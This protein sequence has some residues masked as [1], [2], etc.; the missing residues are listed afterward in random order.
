MVY[1]IKFNFLC[2][3]KHTVLSVVGNLN[4]ANVK[5]ELY[6]CFERKNSKSNLPD[7]NEITQGDWKA[8]GEIMPG[9]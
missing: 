5:A 8:V 6:F 9:S 2:A 1:T 3:G 4:G 7:L